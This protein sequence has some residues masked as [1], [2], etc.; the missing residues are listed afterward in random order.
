MDFPTRPIVIWGDNGH[1][2]SNLLEAFFFLATTRSPF[3][4]SDRQL[5]HWLAWREKQPFARLTARVERQRG[6]LRLEMVLKGRGSE[7]DCTIPDSEGP[8]VSKRIRI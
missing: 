3:A 7:T 2:K 8:R 4:S 1:G 6:A 5:V